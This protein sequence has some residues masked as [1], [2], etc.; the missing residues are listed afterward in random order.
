[1]RQSVAPSTE[2]AAPRSA[3]AATAKTPPLWPSQRGTSRPL[4]RSHSRT[5]PSS[6]TESAW[7]R[8]PRAAANLM[9][10]ILCLIATARAARRAG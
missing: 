3:S 1:M 7:P 9:F 10:E 6:P 5:V 8:S 2:S 4:S